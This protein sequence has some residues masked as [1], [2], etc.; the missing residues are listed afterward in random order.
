MGRI[1]IELSKY[2]VCVFF[3]LYTLYSYSAFGI[4]NPKKQKW[5]FRKQNLLMFLIHGLCYLSLFIGMDGSGF[6]RDMKI[7]LFYVAQII[8]FNITI[9]IYKL[10]YKNLSRLVLNNML[11]LLMLSFVMLTRLSFDKA[12][13]QFFYVCAGLLLC[14]IVPVV[15][16]KFKYLKDLGWL[17][18]A[19]GLAMLL[20]VLVIGKEQ[21]G[22]KNWIMIGSFSFQL[23]EFV[24]ILYVFFL[25]AILSKTKAFHEIVKISIFAAAYVLILV[26]EKDLGGALIF[27]IT[28]LVM[29]YVATSKSLYLFAGLLSGSGA[30][31]VAYQ[32]FNHVRVRVTAWRDPWSV[33]D[34]QGY[35]ITQSLFAIGTGGWFGLGLTLGLP[36]SIPVVASDFIFSAI[37][38][39]MGGIVALCVILICLSCFIM[40]VNIATRM[41]KEFYKLVALG[42]SVVYIFQVFLT[43]GGVTKF[44]PSTGVTLPLVSYG[45]SSVLS[46]IIMFSI[47][48]GL[49]V[50]NQDEVDSIEKERRQ[51]NKEATLG[52]GKSNKPGTAKRKEA[53]Q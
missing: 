24:K 6:E 43:L 15:I 47:I 46:T 2:I 41:K 34:K 23:S 31:V 37:A 20:L 25:A 1:V 53:L 48:Q 49:Y 7:I 29:L 21:Y 16:R 13:R 52:Q 4:K 14:L 3:M 32:L 45:G 42:L 36:T 17:Y 12:L 30:A 51:R 28:Y 40:F 5:M 33:I 8:V 9:L 11:M 26:L 35:Q 44:I 19:V 50:L 27:F 39:E 38:E 10:I 22:A 18:G